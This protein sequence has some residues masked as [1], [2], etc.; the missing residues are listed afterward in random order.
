MSTKS[1][2]I[3][4][5][6]QKRMVILLQAG[7]QPNKGIPS[8]GFYKWF[9]TGNFSVA[10]WS[11]EDEDMLLTQLWEDWVCGGH[12][13]GFHRYK[14]RSQF[15][16]PDLWSRKAIG[17]TMWPYNDIVHEGT[18]ITH[19]GRPYRGTTWHIIYSD[20]Q[21]FVEELSRTITTNDPPSPGPYIPLELTDKDIHEADRRWI[22]GVPIFGKSWS[23]KRGLSTDWSGD[24]IGFFSIPSGRGRSNGD[25]PLDSE[26]VINFPQGMSVCLNICGM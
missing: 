9:N 23:G 10:I 25:S 1:F 11:P 22:H 3:L 6:S 5:K 24:T 4:Y 21:N 19:R 2:P 26:S 20:H 17:T 15:G 13:V 14:H 7:I 8:L 12:H 18:R 16:T